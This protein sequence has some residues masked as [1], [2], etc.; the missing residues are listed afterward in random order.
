MQNKKYLDIYELF[1][2]YFKNISQYDNFY[3]FI[4]LFFLLC[5]ISNLISNNLQCILINLFS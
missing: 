1:V 5:V 4:K 3:F 2:K